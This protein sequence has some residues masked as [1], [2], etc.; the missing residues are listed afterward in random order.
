MTP[1]KSRWVFSVV[2]LAF[3][4]LLF[5]APIARAAQEHGGIGPFHPGGDCIVDPPQ[6]GPTGTGGGDGGDPDDYSNLYRTPND[7]GIE[8]VSD[9]PSSRVNAPGLAIWNDPLVTAVLVWLRIVR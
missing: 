3:L 7:P 8:I 4:C 2:A 1:R 5:S 6:G 9:Q